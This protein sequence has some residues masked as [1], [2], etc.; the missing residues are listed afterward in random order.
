MREGAVK[1]GRGLGDS[2]ETPAVATSPYAAG[3]RTSADSTAPPAPE[4]S[5]AGAAVE[6]T[7]QGTRRPIQAIESFDGLGE[8]DAGGR[9][10]GIDISLAVGPDHIFEILVRPLIRTGIL[11][12]Q[13]R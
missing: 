6:Q 5:A 9:R 11:R 12:R 8:G 10:R 1:A 4:I 3:R 7:A 13:T 2:T